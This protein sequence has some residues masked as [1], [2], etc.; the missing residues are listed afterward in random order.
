MLL[1]ISPQKIW[2]TLALHARNDN[3]Q[4]YKYASE[5]WGQIKYRGAPLENY[6]YS[7][8]DHG[9]VFHKKW[10]GSTDLDSQ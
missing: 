10:E 6:T 8:G 3:V 1:D 5:A 4:K 7:D 9:W 2:P